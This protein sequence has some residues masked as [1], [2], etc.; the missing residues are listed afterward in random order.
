MV[1][2]CRIEVEFPSED[3]V[4]AAIV[5]VSHEGKVGARSS[6]RITKDGKML[7]LHIEADDIVALRATA[8]AYLR[9]LQVFE[10]VE[11]GVND[12]KRK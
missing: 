1:I 10:D 2:N 8:N 12:E 5:A 3:A 7:A 9:A 11:R 4:K 6:A